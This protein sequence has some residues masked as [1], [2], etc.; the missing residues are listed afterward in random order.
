VTCR[1]F[2]RSISDCF[3]KFCKGIL[4]GLWLVTAAFT[5][6]AELRCRFQTILQ[7]GYVAA[8]VLARDHDSGGIDGQPIWCS[9]ADHASEQL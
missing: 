5:A 6:A 9:H 7:V 8:L 4:E 3:L 1:L 2:H